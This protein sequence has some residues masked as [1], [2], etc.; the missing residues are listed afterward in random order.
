MVLDSAQPLTPEIPWWQV[1][2][3][4]EA[5]HAAFDAVSS[6]NLSQG[7]ITARVEGEFAEIVG[8]RFAVAT[9]SGSTALT[10]ALM[11]AGAKPGDRVV[12]PA[13]SWIATA[14]AALVL[15]CSVE[16]VDIEVDRPVIDTEL[17]PVLSGEKVFAIPVHMN[18][19]SANVPDLRDKGYTVIEDAAQALGSKVDGKMLGT[20][21]HIGCF[22]F[23]VSKIVGSGQGGV[24]V[25][26]SEELASSA[27][28][29]RTHG[30]VDVF[31]PDEWSSLG[32]NFRFNDVLGAVLLTQLPKLS[33]RME[34]IR[35]LTLHY[36]RRLKLLPD[37]EIV[38]HST[39]SQVGPYIEARL[40]KGNRDAL[41][42][43]LNARGIGA[44]KAFPPL[45]SA[46]YLTKVSGSNYPNAT[47]WSSNV[48]Y[49]PSGPALSL[50]SVERVCDAVLSFFSL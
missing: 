10:L 20:G 6:K 25:T 12:C 44:R 46:R 26:D 27:V 38:R 16:L 3:G 37:L 8:S 45:S 50:E 40:T 23:S 14:H 29:A 17:I 21:G 30:V 15:G 7:T 13:Y 32:H 36:E 24:L 33:E 22:S 1:D 2:L 39:V 18:G 28:R 19:H 49:L 11:A 4:S 35:R 9:S 41:V 5:A 31:A 43:H 47:L 34:H 48:L 42:Q